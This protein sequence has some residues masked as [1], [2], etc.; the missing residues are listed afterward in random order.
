MVIFEHID[1][2]KT[3]GLNYKVLFTFFD[4]KQ[5]QFKKICE[6]SE[7]CEKT[8]IDYFLIRHPVL[9]ILSFYKN[10]IYHFYGFKYLTNELI[11]ELSKLIKIN[12]FPYK[13]N[14]SQPTKQILN[15]LQ[16]KDTF[17]KF[18]GN[19]SLYQ[20]LDPHLYSQTKTLDIISYGKVIRIEKELSLLR[21]NF[22]DVNFEKREH[23]SKSNMIISYL[24]KPIIEEIY[25]QYTKDYIIGNYKFNLGGI[26]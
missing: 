9:K 17:R 7:K 26:V 10:K 21:K 25:N 22:T 6:Y 3:V 19:L 20:T 14:E 15:R 23:V 16:S 13:I 12:L 18:V 1:T 2:K 11:F 24:D 4:K 8:S 5:D